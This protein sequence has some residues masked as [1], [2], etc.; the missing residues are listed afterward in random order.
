VRKPS[1]RLLRRI[2]DT[3]DLDARELFL[4][5]RPAEARFL[6]E[7]RNSGRQEKSAWQRLA[8]D[9]A[10]RAKARI[11]PAELKVLKAVSLLGRISSERQLLFVLRAIRL[12][13]EDDWKRW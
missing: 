12:A 5:A 11:S 8:D 4:L 3:L 1:L 10:L 6:W 13:I 2:A 9:Q 7:S